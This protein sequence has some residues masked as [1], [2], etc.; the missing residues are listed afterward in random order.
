MHKKWVKIRSWC[1]KM[2][3]LNY[4]KKSNLTKNRNFHLPATKQI[5]CMILHASSHKNTK[6]ITKIIPRGKEANEASVRIIFHR[7]SKVENKNIKISIYNI[8]TRNTTRKMTLSK[9]LLNTES[10]FHWDT[11]VFQNS[12]VIVNKVKGSIISFFV[13]KLILI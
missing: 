10:K 11:N 5:S 13:Q 4:W 9:L 3:W 7:C 1:K 12:K 8:L 2:V 6:K